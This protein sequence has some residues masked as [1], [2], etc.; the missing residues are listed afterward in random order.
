MPTG[1]PNELVAGWKA[2]SAAAE[3]G[4]DGFA[5]KA[6]NKDI[7]TAAIAYQTSEIV[8]HKIIDGWISALWRPLEARAR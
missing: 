7:A 2:S 6:L 8:S 3:E 4:I 5:A 1:D